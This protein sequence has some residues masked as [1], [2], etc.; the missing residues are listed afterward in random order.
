M[1]QSIGLTR[2]KP[3]QVT[4]L[5]GQLAAST[6]ELAVKEVYALLKAKMDEKKMKKKEKKRQWKEANAAGIDAP[7]SP[8]QREEVEGK[9]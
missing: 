2:E 6:R 3:L 9:C 1:E 4:K 7:L 8:F 5:M